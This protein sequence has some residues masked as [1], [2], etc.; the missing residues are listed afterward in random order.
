MASGEVHNVRC[1]SCRSTK[2]YSDRYKC[3][4][5]VDYD[6]CG[7]CFEERCQTKEH[8]S[9]HPM[10]HM[11]IPKELFGQPIRTS[12]EITLTRVQEMLA[13]K[14]HN[15][16]C[17]GCRTSI[18]GARF[19]CD[20]CHSYNLCSSCLKQRVVS[21]QHRSTHPLV[22]ASTE[23]LIKIDIDDIRKGNILGQGGFGSL[24]D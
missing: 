23:S 5:C 7:N 17:D 11:K 21:K 6:L 13:G 3:L 15:L 16:E 18:V 24:I 10:A 4:E 8:L 19:K 20:T 2:I 1:D 22:V 14:K 9:G 12:K